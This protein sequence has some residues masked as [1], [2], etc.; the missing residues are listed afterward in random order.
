MAE[1]ASAKFIQSS[2]RGLEGINHHFDLSADHEPCIDLCLSEKGLADALGLL[3]AASE[4]SRVAG[5]AKAIYVIQVA[6]DPICKIGVSSDP[7]RRVV[8]LQG[9]HYREL[10]LYGVVFCPTHKSV[11]I[12]QDVLS[13]AQ[14]A[15]DR[16]MG[17]WIAAEP[18]AVMRMIFE[19]AKDKRVPI[20]DGRTWFD[21]KVQRTKAEYTARN[22]MSRCFPHGRRPSQ[23][24]DERRAALR[25]K[26][27]MN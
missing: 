9:S 11:T 6:D 17:E 25:Q 4:S 15:G 16:L 26:L 2:R 19:S 24:E 20:C 8:D 3:R 5:F 22:N 13:R 18:R 10:F 21:Y 27:G 1:N 23:Y 7:T 14:D 12:E